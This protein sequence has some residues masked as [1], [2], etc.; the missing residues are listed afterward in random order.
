MVH[1]R[2]GGAV[3]RRG[4]LVAKD[5]EAV[6]A[7]GHEP[8]EPDAAERSRHAAGGL[9][10]RGLVADPPGRI[11]G[12]RLGGAQD[13]EVHARR[14]EELCGGPRDAAPVRVEGPGAADPVEDVGRLA[15]PELAHP[16]VGGPRATIGGDPAERVAAL[17]G[18][19][20]RPG[21][22]GVD[23]ARLH[24]GAPEID[25]L[26]QDLDLERTRADAGRARRAGPGLLGAD[27]VLER[28]ALAHRLE[29]RLDH[30]P[31]IE[32]LTG[33]RRGAHRRAPAAADA[34]GRVE[35][36]S[37]G[38]ALRHERSGLLGGGGEPAG[39]PEL[40]QGELHRRGDH[41][42]EDGRPDQAEEDP[43][44]RRVE[45]PRAP[46]GAAWPPGRPSPP[47]GWRGTGSTRRRTRPRTPGRSPRCAP[48]PG[49]SRSPRWRRGAPGS[50]ARRRFARAGAP[51][52]R[53]AARRSSPRPRGRRAR[54]TRAGTRRRDRRARRE[55]RRRDRGRRPGRSR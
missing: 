4:E 9:A 55:R 47:R 49:E 6:R 38:E 8:L 10:E 32:R 2:D 13:R 26:V 41:V 50:R 37:P 30:A 48:P 14:L 45:C 44:E 53:A 22:R 52:G 19:L 18:R 27:Q 12:A 17:H 40:A 51:G 34:R 28:A 36:L 54:P 16:E 11:P 20:E 46:G 33:R 5:V 7:V 21:R 42:A 15:G 23:G 3:R 43:A 39:S 24:E 35:Q 25:Q 31:G 1:R 29:G